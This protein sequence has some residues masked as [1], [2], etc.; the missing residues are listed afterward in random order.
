MKIQEILDEL[1]SFAP[2]MIEGNEKNEVFR[3][4]EDYNS[5]YDEDALFVGD[6]TTSYLPAF[7]SSGTLV[8]TQEAYFQAPPYAL[9]IIIVEIADIEEIKI[10]L[11]ALL[12]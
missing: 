9:N 5:D 6:E 8:I 3:L 4:A 1:S 12:D 2:K 10:R 7:K 11:R